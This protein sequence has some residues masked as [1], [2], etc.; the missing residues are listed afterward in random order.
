MA[1][2]AQSMTHIPTLSVIVAAH[3]ARVSVAECLAV[4]DAQCGEGRA[5]IIVVDNSTDGTTAIIREQFPHLK[6]VTTSPPALI[7]ELWAIGIQ[8]SHSDIVAITTAHCIPD[9]A[10]LGHI[11]LAHAACVPAVG[12]AIEKDESATGVDWAIY[13]C[14][15]SQYMLPFARRF[16]PEI[17]GDNASYKRFFLDR[18]REV[19]Q[20]GFWEPNVHAEL[21]QTGYQ[22]LLDP[23]IVVRH[24]RSFH[25]SAFVQQRF[26]HGLRFGQ[27]RTSRL[28]MGK[29]TVY[30][31]CAPIVPLV[32][33]VRIGRQVLAKRRH[34]RR[35]VL[36][37][38]L[39]VLFLIAWAV[40]EVAGSLRGTES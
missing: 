40:G 10:W 29:R 12:G 2:T 1:P 9:R 24:K 3:N 16:V 14:R 32:L 27:W 17:A 30:L 15:Y 22:L 25:F 7:P 28:S 23:A 39:L 33:L 38:P 37:S 18:C 19:W 34:R 21:R 11:C 20:H 5:E 26:R 8:P 35:F 13:F 36:V 6:L 4:L 31:L